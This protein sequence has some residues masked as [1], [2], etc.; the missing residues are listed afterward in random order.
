MDIKSKIF[1]TLI[2]NVASIGSLLL[3]GSSVAFDLSYWVTR[4]AWAAELSF[5]LL[6]IACLLALAVILSTWYQAW[7]RMAFDVSAMPFAGLWQSPMAE[8]TILIFALSWWFRRDTPTAP[9]SIALVLSII[10]LGVMAWAVSRRQP[11]QTK[12]V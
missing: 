1:S 9:S 12:K 2:A 4:A 11:Y 6:P 5:W 7:S 8:V 3:F 10:G